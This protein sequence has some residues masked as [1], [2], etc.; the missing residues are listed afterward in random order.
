MRARGYR[1]C[2]LLVGGGWRGWRWGSADGTSKTLRSNAITLRAVTDS[3]RNTKSG[4]IGTGEAV[5]SGFGAGVK[6][7]VMGFVEAIVIVD[8]LM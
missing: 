1:L 5:Q 4:R 2:V 7:R 6:K 3:Q 8:V